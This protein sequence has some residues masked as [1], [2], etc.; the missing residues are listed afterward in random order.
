MIKEKISKIYIFTVLVTCLSYFVFTQENVNEPVFRFDQKKWNRIRYSVENNLPLY[1]E[2]KSTTVAKLPIVTP[3]T[4][5]FIEGTQLSIAGRKLIGMEIKTT[6]YPNRPEYSRTDVNMKQ[7]LQVNIRG[8]VGK[9]VDVN[10]DID[11]TQPDKRDISIIYRGEGVEAGPSAVGYKARPGAFIQEA[12]FGDI[13]LSLPNTEFVGYSRQVF[14]LKV[15]GQYNQAKLYLIASQSKG[16]FEVKRFTG[17]TEFERKILFDTS[18]IRRKYYKLSFGNHKIRKDSVKV[19]L[20]T[21]DPKRDPATLVNLTARAFNISTFTYTGQFQLLAIG[22]DYIVD[23]INGI[24]TFTLPYQNIQ[25]NWV[26]AVDYIDDNSGLSLRELL[27]SGNTYYVLIK[28]KDETPGVTTELLNRY[29]IGRTNI[30]R[31]DGTGN[32]LL[33]IT[34]KSD[35]ILDPAKDKIQPGDKPVPEYKTGNIGNIKVDFENGE[36]YF[37][38]PQPFAEDCYYKT[39]VSRYNIL[40]EYRYRSKIYLLKPFIVPYS[41]RITVDGKI[42]QRNVDYWLDYDSGFITFLKEE[43]IKENSVIEASYE[44]SL[45]GLQGGETIAGGRLEL[46]LANK[47][48]VGSSWIGNLPSKGTTVPDVRTTPSSLQVWEADARL[49]DF[50]IPFIPLKINSFSGE[51]AE[52]EKNPNIWDRAVVEN[53]EG[54]ALE[55]NVSVYRHF[56]Y[57]GSC[58]N[59]YI[60]GSYDTKTDKYVGGELNWE[61]EDVLSKEINPN[62]ASMSEKQQVLKI[63]YNLHTSSEVAMVYQFSKYGLDFSKKLYI[64]V[65][66]YSNSGGGELYIDLGH[67]NEDIDNDGI[68][69]TED[70]NKNGVL[71]INEDVGFVY[72]RNGERYY[73]GSSNGKLDTEDVDDDGLLHT[74]DV[75]VYSEKLA[76]LNFTGWVSTI[77]PISVTDKKLWSS[78]KQL[79]LR[80]KGYKKS[81][82]VK[83]AKIS[84][85][86]NRFE[87]DTPQNTQVY[88]VNNENEPSYIKLTEL[89]EYSS[90]YGTQYKEKIIEQSL[91]IKYK[92]DTYYSSSAVS[93]LYSRG[94]DFTAHHKFNFFVFNKTGNSII[95][96]LRAYTD[97]NNYFQYSTHTL[98]WGNEWKKFVIEQVDINY[99]NIPD[100]W[101]L[102]KE[103]SQGGECKKVGSPNLRTIV[104]L[105]IIISNP[106]NVPQQGVIYI[107][108]IFLSESWKR[109]GIAKKLELNLSIPNWINFG[110]NVRNVDRKFETFTTAI[111]NQ[112]NLSVNGYFDF[113]KL[114]FLP[115]NFKSRQ[116]KTV[117]PSAIQS[118]ELVSKLE[119]GKRVY[120]EGSF[121]IG[122]YLSNMP[123]ISFSYTK[124]VSSTTALSRTD[125]KDNYRTTLSYS[126]PLSLY[127]PLQSISVVFGE[128]KLLLYPWE[129][130]LSTS[131]PVVDNSRYL[132]FNL[133]FNF[134]DKLILNFNLTTKNVFTEIRRFGKDISSDIVIPRLTENVNIF[135]YYT[136]LTFFPLYNLQKTY[137][138]YYTTYSIVVSSYEKRNE[139][140]SEINTSVNIIPFFKPN[141]GYK[142]ELVE[143]YSVPQI[144]KKDVT[145]NASGNF[146]VSFSPKDVINLKQLQTLR[147]NYN[148]NL[149]ASD[150]YEGLPKNVATVNI[151]N[152]QNIDL[153]WYKTEIST[154]TQLRKRM[155]E[156]KDQTLHTSWKLFEGIPLIPHLSFLQKTELNLA[157]SDS[158]EQKEETLTRSI[159]YTKVWPDINSTF[160]NLEQISTFFV[161]SQNVVKIPRLDVIY[162]YR[163][164]EHKN[165][166]F[167]QNIKHKETVTLD[168]F[169]KYQ[170]VSSYE[171]IYN[172]IFSYLYNLKT[173]VSSIDIFSCQV[174]FPFFGQRLTPRYE[175][176]KDYAVDAR[177]MPTKDVVSHSLSVSY[178]ADI[179]PSPTGIKFFGTTLP[180]QNRLRINSSF[181]YTRKESP[182]DISQ[183]NTDNFALTARAD[184]DVSKYINVTLGLGADANINRVVR[185]NT[186]YSFSLQ[187]QVIIRF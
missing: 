112:D 128:E 18:Y 165:M 31:D 182:I 45:L 63:N 168:L 140:G 7:E 32:F 187:G 149:I 176:R 142:V 114:P 106:Q 16:N 170:V 75:L 119:E 54:I 38:D 172:D 160:Y 98:S 100:E 180:L 104:K 36:I 161:P 14:G 76:D 42:L 72:N 127:I 34:D 33:K 130:N 136:K 95:L 115:I 108:D 74:T 133:P 69:D 148:L 155:L 147:L 39:P 109:K 159:V 83:I 17:K 30:I 4:I 91:A 84:V 62:T 139:Y 132:S 121:N 120:T 186:Y 20:D 124:S 85:V 118:G 53:M 35:R 70:L 93:I 102:P 175:F 99:D 92:F 154:F 55:D 13:Q 71:D 10:I 21:L 26:I 171:K 41:E 29:S 59:V 183:N 173:S 73:I 52:N 61:N 80:I 43:E 25:P 68:L 135:D 46:P 125:V 156:R 97:E 163:T 153:L 6:Q 145:R 141:I 101:S 12:A 143:D 51:Y 146:S 78:V 174:G 2:E 86:G 82:V 60:P 64:E 56:W 79:R 137:Q 113:V 66:F 107:N 131:Q 49:V 89:E 11:D 3:T 47:L 50:K 105:Q 152:L 65:E 1:E 81:G 150:R 179:V 48:F 8:K 126:N 185:T 9:N 144:S 23:Y 138:M 28:D 15:T 151:Y 22:K 116:E 178:Y 40:V 24:I 110:G 162:T 184:Y 123:K 27:G 117:T 5:E 19:Y 157:Y 67:M 58:S 158:F 164:T 103:F 90:I 129:L 94:M 167:E 177:K 44:Y 57:Y 181:S 77:V 169:N 88:A 96:S 122:C 111:T 166:S 87:I 37:D 134:W